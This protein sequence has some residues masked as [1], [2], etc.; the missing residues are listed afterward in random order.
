MMRGMSFSLTERRAEGAAD[1]GSGDGNVHVH[2]HGKS[3]GSQL[4]KKSK[5]LFTLQRKEPRAM[6]DIKILS[7]IFVLLL[8]GFVPHNVGNFLGFDGG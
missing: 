7:I 8:V 5:L 4:W 1:A 3:A 6:L 2:V